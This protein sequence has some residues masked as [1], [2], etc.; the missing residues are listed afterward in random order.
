M[1]S[2]STSQIARLA[3][4]NGSARGVRSSLLCCSILNSS[5]DA[6]AAERLGVGGEVRVLQIGRHHAGRIFALLV[7]ADG[8]VGAVVDDDHQHVAA[9]LD[10]GG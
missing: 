9:V 2:D 10:R 4:A 1:C 6:K 8:A 3:G 5:K 7:H